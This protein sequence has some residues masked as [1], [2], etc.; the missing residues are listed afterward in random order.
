MADTR[1]RRMTP[2]IAL[3][4]A[5]LDVVAAVSACGDDDSGAGPTTPDGGGGDSNTPPTP[6][7]DAGPGNGIVGTLVAAAN[8]A[9][10]FLPLDATPSPDGKTVYFIAV[11]TADR[12]PA[13]WKA[14]ASG[15][16]VTKLF[17]GDPLASPVGITVSADGN[18]LY[19]ADPTAATGDTD[20][21]KIFSLASAGGTPAAVAN[22]DGFAPRGVEMLGNDLYFTGRKGGV[23]GG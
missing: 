1:R 21:G 18:T 14:N 8:D 6:G 13:I 16:G 17:S 19:I 5:A 9:Q 20:T 2:P 11:A 3:L 7:N 4:V 23:G 10:F 15:G 12:M 22:T